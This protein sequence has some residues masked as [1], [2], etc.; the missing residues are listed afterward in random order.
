[1][2]SLDNVPLNT[3]QLIV[4]DL[5]TGA[6]HPAASQLINNRTEHSHNRDIETNY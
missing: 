1:M 3:L 4:D 6:K 5:L 2:L